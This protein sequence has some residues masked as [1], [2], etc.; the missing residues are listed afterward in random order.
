MNVSEAI[1]KHSMFFI[2]RR[3]WIISRSDSVFASELTVK[4]FG[5]ELSS[6]LVTQHFFC[7]LLGLPLGFMKT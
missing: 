1:A 3:I 7:R 4:S 5:G 6:S 2:L